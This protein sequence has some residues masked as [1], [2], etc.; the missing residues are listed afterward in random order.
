MAELLLAH[1][2]DVKAAD[3]SGA[4]PLHLAVDR[5]YQKMAELMVEHGADVNARDKSGS[6]PLDEAALR[7]YTAIAGMLIEHGA[8]VDDENPRTR[9]HAAQRGGGQGQPPDRRAAAG[10]GRRSAI[11]AIAAERH[12]SKTPCAARHVAVAELLLD[13]VEAGGAG[14]PDR[15]GRSKGT[16]RNRRSSDCKGRERQLPGTNPGLRRST[17]R[18]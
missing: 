16:D 12:R 1:G 15:R 18:R 9:R 3:N 10:Q 14:R 8:R 4:T 5:G 6:A 17:R 11:A 13:G 7:G 2:A